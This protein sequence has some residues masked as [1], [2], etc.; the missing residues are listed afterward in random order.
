MA[1][2]GV[3]WGGRFHPNQFKT[4][5]PPLAI[6]YAVSDSDDKTPLLR[7]VDEGFV[8]VWKDLFSFSFFHMV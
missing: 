4:T 1:K 3:A 7:G 6:M 2:Q 5:V 8:D